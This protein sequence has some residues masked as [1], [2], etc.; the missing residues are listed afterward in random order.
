MAKHHDHRTNDEA[1]REIFR[2]ID[3]HQAQEIRDAYYKAVEGLRT[4]A[5]ALEIADARQPQSAGPL[6]I[7]HL[8]AIEALDAMK[9]SRLG[10]IL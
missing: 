9:R 8:Y 1:L 2:S 5:D 10:A 4:L 3:A 6:I 7:E